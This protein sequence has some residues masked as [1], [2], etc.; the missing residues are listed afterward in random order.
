MPREINTDLR[1]MPHF[2]YHGDQIIFGVRWKTRKRAF[3]LSVEGNGV[4]DAKKK[5]ALLLHCDGKQMQDIYFTFP[6][7]KESGEN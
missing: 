7:A 6:E 4:T 1:G 5:N 2:E 3:E